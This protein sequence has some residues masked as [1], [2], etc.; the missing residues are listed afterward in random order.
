MTKLTH[1]SSNIHKFQLGKVVCRVPLANWSLKD[2]LHTHEPE[3]ILEHGTI[4][5]TIM[6]IGHVIGFMLNSYNE[7]IVN[8]KWANGS[9]YPIHPENLKALG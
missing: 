6:E 2:D 7:V 3:Y 4:N 8:V 9:E 1:I 5:G